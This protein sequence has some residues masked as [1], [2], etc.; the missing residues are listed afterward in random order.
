MLHNSEG[1][2]GLRLMAQELRKHLGGNV[3]HDENSSSSESDLP[4]FARSI[5][6]VRSTTATAAAGADDDNDGP[7]QQV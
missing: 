1:L 3:V 7:L 6:S 4:P 2:R 5:S